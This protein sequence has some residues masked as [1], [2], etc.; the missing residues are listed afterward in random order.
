MLTRRL[1]VSTKTVDYVPTELTASGEFHSPSPVP[2]EVIEHLVGGALDYERSGNPIVA[3]AMLQEAA[4]ISVL[5]DWRD[6]ERVQTIAF[7]IE[8]G[9]RPKGGRLPDT[10]SSS[11]WFVAYM[12]R[13][14]EEVPRII[15]RG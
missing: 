13:L 15:P 9:V 7:A 8:H 6:D 11:P 14:G 4:R 5:E 3:E 1:V 10:I 12:Y 2:R